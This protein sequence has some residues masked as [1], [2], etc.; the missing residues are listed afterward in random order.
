MNSGEEIPGDPVVS[1]GHATEV[2]E[3]A[4]ATLDDISAFVGAFVEAMDDD[5]VGFVGDDRLGAATNDFAAKVVAVIPARS[6]L[7]G[8]A[9]ARTP[10]AAAAPADSGRL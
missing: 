4:K 10:G 7:M 2:L 5:T 1:G 8:G 6:A 9:S 3:P